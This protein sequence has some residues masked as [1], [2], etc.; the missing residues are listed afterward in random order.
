MLPSLFRSP[1][2]VKLLMVGVLT[3]LKFGKVVSGVGSTTTASLDGSK[4]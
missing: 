2:F 1:V 4:S 3:V